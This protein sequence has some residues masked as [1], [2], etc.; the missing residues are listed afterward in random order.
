MMQGITQT[1]PRLSNNDGKAGLRATA[2]AEID[3]H[4]DN[5][6]ACV[7]WLIAQGVAIEAVDMRRGRSQPQIAV[8]ASSW[9]KTLFR[10]DCSA[11]QHWNAEAG[12][13][14]HDYVAVRYG[15]KITWSEVEA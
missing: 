4:L 14:A 10:D 1:A 6:R 9:L 15:C 11:G 7:H 3:A 12:R 8:V 13:T 5:L 2:L